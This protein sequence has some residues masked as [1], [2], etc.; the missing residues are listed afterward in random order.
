MLRRGAEGGGAFGALAR[1][2]D[3]QAAKTVGSIGRPSVCVVI[4]GF[5][6]TVSDTV[7]PSERMPKRL[8]APCGRTSAA[9]AA[10]AVT[11]I[12]TELTKSFFVTC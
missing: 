3:P 6:H 4:P 5:G 11:T 1:R 7:N 9:P 10:A 8:A 12:R 2:R